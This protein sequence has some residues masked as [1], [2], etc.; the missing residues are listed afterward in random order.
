M[1]SSVR[2]SVRMVGRSCGG[3]ANPCA[4][5]AMRRAVRSESRSTYSGRAV[6]V[7]GAA[8]G[9]DSPTHTVLAL[10]NSF[11]PSAESSRP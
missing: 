6:L 7:S 1:R 11:I 5:S 8:A 2:W 10:Q 9:D 3:S 4:A